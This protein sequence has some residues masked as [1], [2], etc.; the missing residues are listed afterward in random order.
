VDAEPTENTNTEGE[1][2]TETSTEPETGHKKEN[3]SWCMLTILT[4][5]IL[6]SIFTSNV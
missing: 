5:Y 4:N 2:A 6:K 1:T 3:Q